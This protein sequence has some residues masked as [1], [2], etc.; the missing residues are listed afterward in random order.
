MNFL[1]ILIPSWRFFDQPGT[2]FILE[3]RVKASAKAPWGEWEKAF[4]TIPSRK[5]F[6]LFL[7]PS[8]NLYLARV[9]AVDRLALEAQ[10]TKA[11]EH[12]LLE[13]SASYQIVKSLATQSLERE[14]H[15][16]Y[17]FGVRGINPGEV[18]GE[19]VLISP[20]YSRDS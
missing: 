11:A 19:F 8:G 2:R 5:W 16:F 15:F 4:L 20:E 13:K 7:N 3:I 14:K 6:H 18:L 12:E 10:E 1:K 17:Q 9:S